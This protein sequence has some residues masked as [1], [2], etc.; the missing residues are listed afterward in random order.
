MLLATYASDAF[1]EQ[2]LT[3]IAQQ[4]I[5]NDAE[6][7]IV[8]NDRSPAEQAAMDHFRD[9][10]TEQV[11]CF[12]VPR[13]T[14]YASW[15]RGVNA[16]KADLLTIVNV[17]DLRSPA[18]LQAQVTCLEEEP[19]ALFCYG[20]YVVVS[21][22][23]ATNGRAISPPDFD[24]IEFTRSMH[25]GPFF[26][27]RKAFGG[28]NLYFDE[29]FRGGGDFDFVIRLAR[30]GRG[31]RTMEGLG[32][33]YDRGAGLS[34][35]SSLQPTERTVIELRYGIYDK[36]DYH[37]LP[38]ASRYNIPNL[39][40]DGAWHSVAELLPGYEAW[41]LERRG[42]WFRAGL[43]RN[44]RA[45]CWPWASRSATALAR[46]LRKLA[47]AILRPMGGSK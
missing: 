16:A 8:A 29:Q 35:G 32:S 20:P 44:R 39:Y 18:G 28:A 19:A 10:W 25:A 14:L 13:E 27:W 34:T 42:T 47:R 23:G 12:V 43:L 1:I 4:S 31:I 45:E 15:N 3:S 5:W 33:Y 38:E 9:V 2:Q 46:Y 22:F 17:D 6:L 30:L 11:Q 37:Y 21:E 7:V 36:L 26:A 24:A 40:W 41:M